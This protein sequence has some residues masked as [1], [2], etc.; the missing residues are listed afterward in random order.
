MQKA[1]SDAADP[2]A[3]AL[4]AA[5]TV[6]MSASATALPVLVALSFC[7][8]LNDMMQSLIPSLYPLLKAEFGLNFTQVGL[9]ALA[10]Q[11][12]ASMLQPLVGI[13]SDR[14]SMPW[15]LPIG[16]GFTL[17]GLL[18]L[19]VAHSFPMVVVSAMLVGV[20]SAVFHPE[21]S[22]VARMAS[23]GR[24]GFAQSLFQVGGNSGGAIGP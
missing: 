17:V 2:S 13:A 7:H 19:S 14:R 23:G 3:N 6:P 10:F 8:M 21:S 11:L 4:A 1:V 18:M 20:G 16:M 9:I 15:S 12:T 24:Y 5:P 22:R